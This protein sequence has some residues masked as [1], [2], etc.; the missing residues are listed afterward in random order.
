MIFVY[1]YP[2]GKFQ[3]SFHVPL[4]WSTAFECADSSGDVFVTA[5]LFHISTQR[6]YEYAHGGSEP[7]ATLTDPGEAYACAVDPT[8]GNLAVINGSDP[9]NPYNPYYGDVAVYAAAQGQPTMYYSSEFTAPFSDTYDD[10][11]NLYMLTSVESSD[12][13]QLARL[14]YGRGSFELVKLNKTVNFGVSW[15]P[16]LQWDGKHVT[17]SS[18]Q[19]TVTG[20][21]DIYQLSISG[22]SARVIGTTQLT[23]R[24]QHHGGQSWIAGNTVVGIYGHGH[25]DI[26]LWPYPKGGK[27]RSTIKKISTPREGPLWGVTVSAAPPR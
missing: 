16:T 14:A 27:P 1:T 5:Q 13:V 21:V 12:D 26:A 2:E 17:V 25:S 4:P 24:Q 11:G 15:V 20:P 3:Q 7:I 18:S 6:I 23:V 9:G 19:D 8:T 10:S 22:S